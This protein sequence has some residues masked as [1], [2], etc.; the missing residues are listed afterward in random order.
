M[1]VRD[2]KVVGEV[3][4]EG[5]SRGDDGVDVVGL[6]YGCAGWDT[7]K[8]TKTLSIRVGPRFRVSVS[9]GLLSK[10]RYCAEGGVSPSPTRELLRYRVHPLNGRFIEGKLCHGRDWAFWK[11]LGFHQL[12]S[13]VGLRRQL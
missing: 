6:C 4:W 5:S 8:S 3:T 13:A 12:G 2:L 11:Y 10:E 9:P 1:W 7:Y